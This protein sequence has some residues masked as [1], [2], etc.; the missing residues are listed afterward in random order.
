[1]R[2]WTVGLGRQA[3]WCFDLIVSCQDQCRNI[4]K[5]GRTVRLYYKNSMAVWQLNLGK[6]QKLCASG[7]DLS[8]SCL[9]NSLGF[10]FF[11]KKKIF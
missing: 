6:Y 7:R 3:R 8:S 11:M 4:L 10:K 5:S 9:Q 2:I 1:M